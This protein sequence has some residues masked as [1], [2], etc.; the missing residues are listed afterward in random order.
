MHDDLA[1]VTGRTRRPRSRVVQRHTLFYCT[2]NIL[3][4]PDVVQAGIPP[5]RDGASVRPAVLQITIVAR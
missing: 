5:D 2:G 1:P 4:R 3:A